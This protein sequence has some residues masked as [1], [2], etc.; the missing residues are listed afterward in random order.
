MVTLANGL[1]ERG[2]AV[3][4][5][6]ASCEGPFLS[7]V[8]PSV[9]IVDLNA[10]RVR[11]SI[12]RLASYLRRERPI[13]LLSFQSHANLIAIAARLIA[14]VPVR[15]VVSERSSLSGSGV[16]AGFKNRIVRL[17]TRW[18]YRGA[19]AVTV[20]AE[21]MIDELRT[22]TRLPAERVVCIPNPMI[23]PASESLA[24]EAIDHPFGRASGPPLVVTAG[25]L[26]PEKDFSTLLRAF[27]LLRQRMEVKLLILG[28][29]DSRP[30][31]QALV[32][33]L[34]LEEDVDLPG[35]RSNPLPYMK[36]AALYVLSS[37]FEGLPGALIQ[38][39]GV[40]TPVVSTDCLTGPAEIL[41]N[42]RWGTLVPVGDVEAL[43]AAMFDSLT[44]EAVPDVASRAQYYNL[45][46]SVSAY[47][48]LL[49]P[50]GQ[51]L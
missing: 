33:E 13:A 45:D 9:R 38:A 35:F 18:A 10:D 15:L 41:E 5:L 6:L 19:D 2:A 46:R 42:G 40:G 47:L 51:S 11:A 16:Q 8:D 21:A 24:G 3:T 22:A 25:R 23:T 4:L 39:M 12:F 49:D 48:A 36:A 34:G 20:V 44:A 37:K 7:R 43:A 31:L 1:A 14:G 26:A 29:G 30:M 28:E 50:R 32:R 17:L 27:A